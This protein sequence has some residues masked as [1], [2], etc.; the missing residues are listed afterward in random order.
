[1]RDDVTQVL[2]IQVTAR[3]WR[4]SRKHLL[5]L[6]KEEGVSLDSG[7]KGAGAGGHPRVSGRMRLPSLQVEVGMARGLQPASLTSVLPRGV[8]V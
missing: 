8:T 3:I 6:G 7:R 1:M 5:D 4:E 2:V